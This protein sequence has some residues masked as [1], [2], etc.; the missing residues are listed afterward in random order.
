MKTGLVLEGGAMRGMYTAGILDV[1][2]ENNIAVDMVVGVSAGA[3][4]GVNFLSRQIGRV[5]RYNK[6]F[7]G[8]KGYM[9]LLP[10]L[11][12]G[13]VVSAEFAYGRVPRELDPF[14]DETYKASSIPFYAVVANIKTGEA[15]Y[16]QIHS[17]F[18]QMDTLRASGSM[19]FVSKPV[20]IG[21]ETY[22]DGAI[23]DSIPFE[24]ALSAGF[25]K[26][27]VVLTRD[28]SYTKKPMPSILIRI[29]KKKYPKIAQKLSTQHL[30][31]HETLDRLKTLEAEGKAFVI[32]PSIPIEI[33]RIEKDPD[34]LQ[35][36][37]DI[38][39]SDGTKMLSA[40]KRFLQ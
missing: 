33:G 12:E 26:L 14:D 34:K 5:I 24:W 15:E 27:I 4:F 10:L 28:E 31:Y 1:M 29:Y 19:P 3:A 18:E 16:K 40:L 9:G 21:D 8:A 30:R 11:R 2:M 36:V 13:N 7:N 25:E 39:R 35:A 37:Y 17:V 22:L 6:Q 32:R 23:A 38:G 20:E